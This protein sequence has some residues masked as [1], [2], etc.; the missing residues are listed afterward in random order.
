MQPFKALLLTVKGLVF[1]VLLDHHVGDHAHIGFE[2]VVLPRRAG[3]PLMTPLAG[4]LGIHVD[5]HLI[6]N[7][8]F[9]QFLTRVLPHLGQGRM[10]RAARTEGLRGID[11]VAYV[12]FASV[13]RRFQEATDF[14]HEVK[15]LEAKQ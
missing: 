12:R 2:A 4:H 3:H 1:H 7:R 14:V 5:V 6:L 11:E 15:K 10:I 8:Q 9:D 13:Y